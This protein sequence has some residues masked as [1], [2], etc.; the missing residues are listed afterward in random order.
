MLVDIRFKEPFH[1]I[2]YPNGSRNSACITYGKG[3]T[4][5]FI[6]LPL[7]GCNTKKVISFLH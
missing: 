5:Y 4:K 7:K 6:E 2:I 3:K 1:G